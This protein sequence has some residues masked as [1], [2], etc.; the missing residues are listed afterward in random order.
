MVVRHITLADIL[1]VVADAVPDRLALITN[2]TETTYRVLDERATRLANHLHA[3]GIGP[4]DHIG[5]HATNCPEWVEAFYA[6]FKIRAV[7]ININYRY[8]ANE[9][10]HLYG[11]SECAAVI[12]APEFG[13]ALDE[14]SDS[15]PRLRH[16]LA[17]GEE[18]EAALAA[19]SPERDF[20]ERSGDDLYIVY[21][22]GTTGLPKGVM[23]RQEDI[24]LGASNALRGGRPIE[25]VEQLG[26]EAAVNEAPLRIMTAG[27]MMHGGSQWVLTNAHIAGGTLVLYTG[28]RFDAHEVLA[29]AARSGVNSLS[30]LGDAMARPLAEALLAPDR[31]DYDLSRL[32]AIANGAA[33]LSNAVRDQLRRALPNVLILDSY[34]SSETGTTGSQV[35]DGS[36]HEAPRFAVGEDTT[37][38]DAEFH[39]CPVGEVGM[40]ARSGNIP[41]GYYND[42]DKTAATFPVV[43]GKRWVIAGD[44][45]RIEADGTISVLGRGS[46]SINSGG[47]KIFPEEVEAALVDHPAIF[48]AAV[49]GTP[50]ERWGQQVTALVQVRDG[51]Q[52][53]LDEVRAHCKTLIADYK[54]PK[55]V[56]VVDAVPRTPVGKVDY[57]AAAALAAELLGGVS[58]G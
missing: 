27:P 16:R 23:W 48:D 9:L 53:C 18:Y 5:I 1:E 20:P 54:A 22:G 28:A 43:D 21:T 19:A 55:A 10:R 47:E 58:D 11:N 7:P 56:L 44:Y 35:D 13:A 32:G 26:T 3:Q 49:V 37:V 25:S 12:V 14:V 36:A 52:V 57:K 24:I 51:A 2:G 38:L 33:P 15:L 50:S 34:G 45:A 29:L 6:A 41:L 39:R 30:T 42:P 4:G 40:L 31:P 17:L 8:V 46:V